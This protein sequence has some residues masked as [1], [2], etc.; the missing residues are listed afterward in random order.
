[1]RRAE[2][3]TLVQTLLPSRSVTRDVGLIGAGCALTALAAQIQI[4]WQPVPFT[5]QTLAVMLCGLGMGRRLGVGSQLLYL[6]LGAGG[7]PVFAGASSGLDRLAG[8]TGGYLVSFVVM[9]LVLGWLSE[10]GCTRTLL[11]M[12]SALAVGIVLNLGLGTLWLACFIGLPAALIGGCVPFLGIEV[13]KAS[14]V[15]PLLPAAWKVVGPPAKQDGGPGL[16]S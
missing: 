10:R 2:S 4:P 16:F 3:S 14:I 1:M 7:V 13:L 8:P 9:S 5:L 11:G 12:A 6:I 15:L